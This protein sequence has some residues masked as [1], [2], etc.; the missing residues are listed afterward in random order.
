[1]SIHKDEEQQVEAIKKW[2]KEYGLTTIAGVVI[3]ILIVLGWQYYQRAEMAKRDH[4]SVAYETFITAQMSGDTDRAQSAANVLLS[5]FKKT[6]Y[7]QLA[8]F[9]LAKM[10]VEKQQY[11]LANQ[12]LMEIVQ[13]AKEPGWRDIARIRLARINLEQQQ[14]QQALTQLQSVGQSYQGLANVVRGDAYTQLKQ[15]AQA[16]KAYHQALTQL[17][18]DAPINALIKMKLAN[19]PL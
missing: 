2:W 16:K 4:A 10:A 18:P 6:S 14:S 17:P 7:A 3:A 12:H 15:F 9:W 11:S 8:E 1:M 19:L 13:H 5:Q